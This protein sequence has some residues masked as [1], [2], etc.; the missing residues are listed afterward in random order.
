MAEIMIKIF[1][2]NLDIWYQN[3]KLVLLTT[4]AALSIGVI[5]KPIKAIIDKTEANFPAR[6]QF[7]PKKTLNIGTEKNI[8]IE[9]GTIE[10]RKHFFNV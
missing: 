6:V 9:K 3:S 7:P 10:N 5:K 1:A 4:I 8:N 2:R